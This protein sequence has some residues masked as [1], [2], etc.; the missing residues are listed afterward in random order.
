MTQ[1]RSHS[2]LEVGLISEFRAAVLQHLSSFPVAHCCNSESHVRVRQRT[3]PCEPPTSTVPIASTKQFKNHNK[4]TR[5]KK[6]YEAWHPAW[7]HHS[8]HADKPGSNSQRLSSGLEV[9]GIWEVAGLGLKPVVPEDHF[10]SPL[11]TSQANGAKVSGY[12][13]SSSVSI[14]FLFSESIRHAGGVW[15]E[16]VCVSHSVMSDSLRFH[17]L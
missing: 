17:G 7:A 14:S 11:M 1:H 5:K 16:C 9:G 4:Q 3:L 12:T 6:I 15:G 2:N 10:L 8:I 13:L